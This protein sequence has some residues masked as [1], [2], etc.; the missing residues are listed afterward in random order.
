[1]K[2]RLILGLLSVSTLP[3]TA[4]LQEKLL[5]V[6]TKT[7]EIKENIKSG[8]YFLVNKE[9]KPSCS[10]VSNCRACGKCRPEGY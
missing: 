1:M 4:T 3:A 2:S 8:A 6:A 9:C 5:V 7:T 10:P